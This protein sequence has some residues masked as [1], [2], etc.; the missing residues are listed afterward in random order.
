MDRRL[1]AL[2]VRPTVAV[3]HLNCHSVRLVDMILVPGRRV[4][5]E[6]AGHGSRPAGY[7][8]SQGIAVDIGGSHGEAPLPH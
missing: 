7:G 8:V 4:A 2:R 1:E 6:I 3:A 5:I